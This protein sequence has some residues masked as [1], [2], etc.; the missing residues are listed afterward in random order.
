[1]IEILIP[2][3]N[4]AQYLD[5]QLQSI[6]DQDYSDWRILIKDDGSSDDTKN[7]ISSWEKKHPKKIQRIKE[8]KEGLGVSQSFGLLIANSTSPYVMLCDQDDFWRPSKVGKSLQAIQQAESIYGAQMP[9]MVCTDL[10]I[11]DQNLV[12]MSSSFWQDR[13]DTPSILDHYE[14]LIAHSVVTG[15]T[16]MLNR[17][18]K[19]LVI[20]IRTNFFLYDQWISI[21]VARY[22]KIIFLD[23]T[24][25]KYRQHEANVLGSFKFSRTYLFKKVKYIPY[26]IISWIKLKKELE[27]DF[28]VLSVLKFKISYN[29]RKIFNA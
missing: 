16:I 9:L 11:V 28:S 24:L 29:I 22:G 5:L 21:K 13:K 26:Y 4:G 19:E 18:A 10:E 8:R 15:N 25:V 20:P 1:M 12:T 3:F 23:E 7:I 27:M 2:T 6:F 14:K 17:K